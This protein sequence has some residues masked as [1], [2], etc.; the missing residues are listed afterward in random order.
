VTYYAD[1]DDDCASD[2]D[3]DAD[4]E[5]AE[6]RREERIRKA[7]DLAYARGEPFDEPETDDDELEEDE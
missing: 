4:D 1:Y 2:S 5:A 7:R 6:A 3:W